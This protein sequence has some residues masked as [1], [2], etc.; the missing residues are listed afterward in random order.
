MPLDQKNFESDDPAIQLVRI[1]LRYG[2][3]RFATDGN[4]VGGLFVHFQL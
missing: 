4:G 1:V 3:N 2:S